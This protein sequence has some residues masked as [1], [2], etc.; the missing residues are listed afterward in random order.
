MPAAKITSLITLLDDD[1]E[2]VRSGVQ[3]ALLDYQGDATDELIAAGLRLKAKQAKLLSKSLHPG[4]RSVLRREWAYPAGQLD[5]VDG[6]WESFEALLRLLSDFLHDGITMRQSLSDELD[7]LADG[8]SEKVTTAAELARHLFGNA[9]LTGN[10]LS[11]FHIKN[12]DLAWC[13]QEGESNPL[14]LSLIY[15]LVANRLEI[16]VFGCNY[17]GHFL[18]LIDYE[19]EATIVDPFHNGRLTSLRQLLLDHPEISKA[20]QESLKQPC[21]LSQMLTRLLANLHYGFA[22]VNR[23]KDAKLVEELMLTVRS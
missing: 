19:G 10:R 22:Q 6:D 3:Q 4:R 13:I 17:P 2:E 16:P 12:S 11:P 20:A 18:S 23:T 9:V 14:G 1:T 5:A 15:M 7:L 21:T 8:A